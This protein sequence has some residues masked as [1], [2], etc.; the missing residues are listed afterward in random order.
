MV[1]TGGLKDYIVYGGGQVLNLVAPIL[2]VP[3]IIAVCGIDN[4]G[5]VA[6]AINTFVLLCIFIDF[7]SQLLGVKKLSIIKDDPEKVKK[8]LDEMYTFRI[9]AFI[10][11]CV[12]MLVAIALLSIEKK[13]YFF[14]ITM[15]LAQL[16]NPIWIYQSLEKFSTINYI[17]F[18]SKLLYLAS[19]YAFITAKHLYPVAILCLGLSN[20]VVYGCFFIMIIRKYKLSFLNVRLKVLVENFKEEYPL[21]ISNFSIAAYTFGPIILVKLVANDTV[22][23]IYAIGNILLTIIRSYLAVFFNVSFPKFCAQYNSDSEKGLSFLKK[24]NTF[25]LLFIVFGLALLY[26]VVPILAESMA[27]EGNIYDSVMICLKFLGLALVIAINIPFYQMLLYHNKQKI[28]SAI[29]LA[30]A[31]IMVISCICLT[32]IMSVNGSILSLYIVEV[33]ITT[34]LIMAYYTKVYNKPLMNS[35]KAL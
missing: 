35:T 27:L 17:V 4:N 30:G 32:K 20:A 25:H 14:G 19:V 26:I 22:V 6:V 24:I 29:S 15:L 3:H 31:L 2:I 7:G 13:L 21:V 8:L 11:L 33:F 1:K 12:A 16:V 18:F 28:V 34:A 9:F 23:G 5:K 10:V